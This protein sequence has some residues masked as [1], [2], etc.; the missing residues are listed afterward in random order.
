MLLHCPHIACIAVN[1]VFF[2]AGASLTS[3]VPKFYFA[4]LMFYLGMGYV[5]EGCWEQRK[6]L[7]FWENTIVIVVS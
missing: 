2:F 7:T 6:E 5:V 3:Y 1:V 4:G